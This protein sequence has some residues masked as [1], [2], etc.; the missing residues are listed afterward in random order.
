MVVVMVA[1]AE[2]YM[3]N[4]AMAAAEVVAVIFQ[5]PSLP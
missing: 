2:R 1:V 5:R 4:V 3:A